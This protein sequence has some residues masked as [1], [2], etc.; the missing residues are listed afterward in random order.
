MNGDLRSCQKSLLSDSLIGDTPCPHSLEAADIGEKGTLII[1]GQAH[2]V[3][4]GKPHKAQN[5]GDFADIFVTSVL[6]IG[7]SFSRI[8]I[9]FDRYYVRLSV[10][11][12]TRKK[13][14]KGSAREKRDSGQKCASSLEIGQLHRTC[15]KQ[16][17]FCKILVAAAASKG[18]GRQDHCCCRR[19]Q[20]CSCCS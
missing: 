20:H 15:S 19:I 5:F 13:R 16:S 12:S 9:I 4:L 7:A 8:D 11:S 2:V 18:T 14:G 1:D 6:Q 10:K 17:R 3:A